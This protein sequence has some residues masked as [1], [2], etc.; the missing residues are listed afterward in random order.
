MRPKG[1]PA[2]VV[3]GVAFTEQQP[4]L[5]TSILVEGHWVAPEDAGHCRADGTWESY[6][7]AIHRLI[8]DHF[9]IEIARLTDEIQLLRDLGMDSLDEVELLTLF[10]D[11]LDLDLDGIMLKE[12]CTVGALTHVIAQHLVAQHRR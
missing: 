2:S 7:T 5:P 1:A 9:R 10:E 4:A 6:A 11:E 3:Y 8:G 12:F